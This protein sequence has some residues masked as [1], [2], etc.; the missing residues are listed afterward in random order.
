MA[1][2]LTARERADIAEA[3]RLDRALSKHPPA[4]PGIEGN[5]RGRV[6]VSLQRSS[7]Q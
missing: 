1:R 4:V 3:F 2:C 7:G 5:P 6:A